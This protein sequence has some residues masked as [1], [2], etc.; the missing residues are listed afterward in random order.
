MTGPNTI[1]YEVTYTDPLVYTAPWTARLDWQRDN[2]F[3]IFEYACHEGNVQVRNYITSSRAAR[4]AA[5][6]AAAATPAPAAAK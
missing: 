4:A 2:G 1:T 5:A 6:S 3:E